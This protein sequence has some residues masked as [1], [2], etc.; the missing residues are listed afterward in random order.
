MHETNGVAL[1][2]PPK[3]SVVL[4]ASYPADPVMSVVVTPPVPRGWR[5]RGCSRRLGVPVAAVVVD[6]SHRYGLAHVRVPIV[7]QL[8]LL[9]SPFPA[10]KTYIL[11]RPSLP[12]IAA[13]IAATV[14]GPGRTGSAR[15]RTAPGVGVDVIVWLWAESA[16]ADVSR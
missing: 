9:A 3:V 2:V 1:E 6:R 14:G 5:L 7:V 10:A 16:P 12:C 15:H 13:S 4:P 11:P 8:S